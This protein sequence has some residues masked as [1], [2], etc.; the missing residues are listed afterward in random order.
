MFSC[1]F[2]ALSL[3]LKLI[4]QDI[5]AMFKNKVIV[6]EN[7]GGVGEATCGV[8]MNP[9]SS[10]L[11]VENVHVQCGSNLS[12]NDDVQLVTIQVQV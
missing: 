8:N 5:F 3:Q 10:L 4:A 2:M 12:K 9:I 6:V 11:N 7:V 1:V